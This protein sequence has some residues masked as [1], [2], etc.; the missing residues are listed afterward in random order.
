MRFV[1]LAAVT[2]TT[3]FATGA[4]SA[5][6]FGDWY[7]RADAGTSFRAHAEA[8][9][10]FKGDAG[11]SLSGAAGRTFGPN[12]RAEAEI[13]YQTASIKGLREG[14]MRTFGGFANGYYH[15]N[16]DG[17]WQ[18]FVGAGVGVARVKVHRE[19]DAGFAYQLK[20]GIAHPFSDRL[21][22]ELAYRY[23][24]VSNVRAGAGPSAFDGKYHDEAVVVGVRYKLGS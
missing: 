7:V 6:D 18:P 8:H 4:A 23:M 16:P 19:H 24:Q 14:Q 21:S 15:F 9:P 5:Q 12:L 10:A 22:G 3:A 11:W 17:A 1:F 13:N 20:A 2:A